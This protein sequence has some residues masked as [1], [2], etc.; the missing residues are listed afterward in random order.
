MSDVA[1]DRDRQPLE[2]LFVAA[3]GQGVEQ[4]LG[5]MLVTAVARVDD[6]AIDLLRQKLNRAG[7]V[8]T[9]NQQIGAHRVQRDGRIDQRLAFFDGRRRDR[10]VHHVGAEALACEFER[11]LGAGR[12]F[13]EKIDERPA[14]QVAALLVDPAALSRRLFGEVEQRQDLVP[15][16]TFD[17][18]KVAMRE[19]WGRGFS[20]V[21]H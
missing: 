1:T 18:K 16:Q 2:A 17:A 13:E 8:M 15:L 5:G 6:R 7:R 10:H 21:A 11:A 20:H 19:G 14:A 4:G 3:N 12:G 9:H